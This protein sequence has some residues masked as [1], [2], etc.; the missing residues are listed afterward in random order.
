MTND[1]ITGIFFALLAGIFWGAYLVPSK[2]V[3]DSM[4]FIAISSFFIF[5]GSLTFAL[6]M[7]RELLVDLEVLGW[8]ALAGI[9]WVVG[10]ISANYTIKH[11]GLGIGYTMWSGIQVMVAVILG[12]IVLHELD[13]LKGSSLTALLLGTILVIVGVVLIGWAR[14]T[15][16]S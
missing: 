1:T 16:P 14:S 4:T 12:A 6:L 9:M 13:N 15:I 3:S 5:A 10:Y 11:I 8:S 2:K 7:K